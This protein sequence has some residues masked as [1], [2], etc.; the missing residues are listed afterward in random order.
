[1]T[2]SVRAHVA[3][4]GRPDSLAGQ[5]GQLGCTRQL[6]AA[7]YWAIWNQSAFLFQKNIRIFAYLFITLFCSASPP[8]QTL[9]HSNITMASLVRLASLLKPAAPAAARA[10]AP[11]S[12]GYHDAVSGIKWTC[13]PPCLGLCH[14]TLV[15]FLSS[16][17]HS[18]LGRVDL[19]PHLALVCAATPF[20]LL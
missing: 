18:M 3:P 17:I 5:L 11:A 16:R 10:F 19:L 9:S 20:R 12:R 2:I 13:V 15:F 14:L 8:P 6:G 1:M 4:T 7:P